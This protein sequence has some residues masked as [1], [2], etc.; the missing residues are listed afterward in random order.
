[1]N[2]KR[3][4]RTPE[5]PILKLEQK[6]YAQLLE[7]YNRFDKKDCFSDFSTF[8]DYYQRCSPSP[9]VVFYQSRF[10]LKQ[11]QELKKDSEVFLHFNKG[12]PQERIIKDWLVNIQE[13]ESTIHLCFKEAE[14]ALE[15]LA[16]QLSQ[17]SVEL[18]PSE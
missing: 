6:S 3:T 4:I 8:L 12:L 15:I 11:I 14:S 10:F 18:R 5:N 9:E 1:M 2:F 16:H 7:S 13:V 17:G